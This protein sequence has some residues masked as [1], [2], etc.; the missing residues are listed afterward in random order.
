M[1]K[2]KRLSEQKNIIYLKAAKV[3]VKLSTVQ[4][5]ETSSMKPVS[6]M[7]YNTLLTHFQCNI[8]GY[9]YV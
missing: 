3:S 2:T 1:S 5:M 9:G 8:G 4:I 6:I 7:H